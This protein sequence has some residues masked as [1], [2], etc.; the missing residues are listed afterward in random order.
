M[1]LA[2]TILVLAALFFGFLLLTAL[3][4]RR[5]SRILSRQ[6][7]ALDEQVERV[8]TAVGHLDL[9]TLTTHVVR[10]GAERLLHDAVHVILYSVRLAERLLARAARHLRGRQA[11]A[12]HTGNPVKEALARFKQALT[13]E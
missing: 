11:A 8:S 9:P 6:R 10:T 1:Y 3:E 5:G 13:E 2:A 7:E 12:P 4:A